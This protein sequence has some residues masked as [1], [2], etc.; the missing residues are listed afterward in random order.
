[1]KQ[2][3]IISLTRE[4]MHD[5]NQAVKAIDYVT[6][7]LE[8]GG[9]AILPTETA[10]ALC[11]DATSE[12]AVKKVFEIKKRDESKPIPIMVS[13][14]YMI[15]EYAEL[16]PLAKHLIEAFMPGPLTLIV[17]QKQDSK[18]PKTLSE[19]GIAFRIPEHEFTRNVISELGRP[20][21]STSANIAGDAAMY[22]S[23]DVRMLFA[24]K[25]QVILDAGNLAQRPPSTILDL[26]KE[27]PEIIRLGPIPE[28]DIQEEISEFHNKQKEL[29]NTATTE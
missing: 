24:D 22:N 29:L 14:L 27:K 25:V 13:D 2:G 1:M 17:P 6:K 9:I 8:K 19:K 3:K 5:R 21:T 10:Y 23:E 20:I 11:A 12:E 4:L 16:T 7:E 26:L 18:L 28:E 15:Q